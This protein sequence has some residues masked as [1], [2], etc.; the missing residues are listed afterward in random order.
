MKLLDEIRRQPL[1]IRKMFMWSLVVITFA[2]FG[3]WRLHETGKRVTALMNPKLE[4]TSALAQQD[5]PA[6]RQE[7]SKSPFALIGDSLSSLRASI[8]ELVRRKGGSTPDPA[9]QQ[10]TQEPPRPQTLP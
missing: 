3:Y 10:T 2:T 6:G 4:T 9:Q 7:T 5:L 8:S 1:H